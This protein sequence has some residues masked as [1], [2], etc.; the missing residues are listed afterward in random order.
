MIA[1]DVVVPT[2]IASPSL[3]YDRSL[4]PRRRP[5]T[6]I[7]ANAGLP[8]DVIVGKLLEQDNPRWGFNAAVGEYTD[9]IKAGIIDPTKVVRTALQDASSVAALMTTAEAAVAD[10]PE[11]KGAAPAGG[12]GGGGMGGMG[13]MF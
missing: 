2:N 13:G 11:E 3:Y 4:I 1:A 9:M 12:M 5:L 10:L 7:A 6:T 8:G